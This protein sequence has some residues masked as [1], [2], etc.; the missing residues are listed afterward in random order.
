MNT[1]LNVMRYQSAKVEYFKTVSVL[2]LLSTKFMTRFSSSSVGGPEAIFKSRAMD[3]TY[4]F[5]DPKFAPKT[6]GGRIFC[7][8]TAPRGHKSTFWPTAT[9]RQYIYQY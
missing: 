8:K 3:L 1:S 4:L 2:V 7:G 6:R 5:L 9:V